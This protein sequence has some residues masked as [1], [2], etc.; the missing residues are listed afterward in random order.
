MSEES[1][2]RL[3]EGTDVT[4]QFLNMIR[5]GLLE[6]GWDDHMAQHAAIQAVQG[7]MELAVAEIYSGGRH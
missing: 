4:V 3:M 2:L 7:S 1:I 6:K 5:Q